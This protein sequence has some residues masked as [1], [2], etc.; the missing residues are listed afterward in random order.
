[1]IFWLQ[2]V[3]PL[4]NWDKID[5]V[6]RMQ[7]YIEEHLTEP[8]T[9]YMLA[10]AVGYSPWHASRIFKNL[11]GKTPLEYIRALRLSRAVLELWDEDKR[12]IDVAFDF[13]FASHEGFTRAFSDKFGMTP[14]YYR[15]KTP[16]LRLFMPSP[17]RSY[18]LLLQKGVNIVTESKKSNIVFV[19]V[20]ERPARKLI[21]RRGIKADNYFDYCKEVGCEVWGIL[22]S[23]KEALYEPIGM[24]LPENIRTPGTSIYAQGVEVPLH[25]TGTAPDEFEMIE[26]KP[27]KYM[28][29]QGPP[30]DNE[31]FMEAIYDLWQIM[32]EYNAEFYGFTWADAKGPRFQLEPQGERGYI[33]ARPVVAVKDA[34]RDGSD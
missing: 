7:N 8:I 33:E 16:P 26:L 24:W 4:E 25:Y 15:K 5:A 31:E 9:L 30:F 14:Q 2:E 13:S 17:I 1:M 21:L 10:Q 28:V 6:Q 11:I 32:K 20:V 27:C 34:N 12:I 22:C 23:I 18:Y 19:Q 29:F 3:R